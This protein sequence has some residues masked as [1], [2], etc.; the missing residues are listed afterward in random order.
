MT[1]R[2]SVTTPHNQPDRSIPTCGVDPIASASVAA[3]LGQALHSSSHS[4]DIALVPLDHQSIGHGVLLFENGARYL[5][6]IRHMLAISL[7]HQETPKVVMY[8]YRDH[9][10]L[11]ENDIYEFDLT[12]A[13][14]DSQGIQLSDWFVVTARNVRSIPTEFGRSTNWPN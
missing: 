3:L 5:D 10:V 6:T 12:L 1:W 7:D 14:L 4:S 9:D 8:S 11:D 2:S 13:W